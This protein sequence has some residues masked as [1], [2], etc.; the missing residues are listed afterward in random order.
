MNTPVRNTVFSQLLSLMPVG[1]RLATE[2]VDFRAGQ[3]F[4]SPA[5]CMHQL[6]LPEQGVL[7]LKSGSETSMTDAAL[8]GNAGGWMLQGE[9]DLPWRWMALSDGQAHVLTLPQ[10]SLAACSDVLLR[11]QMGL[12][13]QVALWGHCRRHHALSERLAMLLLVIHG[14]AIRWCWPG[15]T[16]LLQATLPQVQEALRAL[17]RKA[18]VCIDGDTVVIVQPAA[19]AHQA[20]T[21]LQAIRSLTVSA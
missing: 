11:L 18:V 21:C 5:V 10:A 15:W 8:L 12:M 1:D 6:V 2:L 19:L 13:R 16:G 3:V 20:C 4:Q 7:V 9:P 17:E 14:Q